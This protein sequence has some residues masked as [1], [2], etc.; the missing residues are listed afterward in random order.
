MIGLR[1]RRR[2]GGLLWGVGVVVAVAWGLS[3]QASGAGVRGLG[4]SVAMDV[5]A[6]EEG[7]LASLDVDLHDPVAAGQVL[8][9][10]DGSVIE[11]ERRELAAEVLAVADENVS[12]TVADVKAYERGRTLG[13]RAEIAGLELQLR[14]L[15]RLREEGAATAA[16]V[17]EVRAKLA[18]TRAKLAPDAP[19]DDDP[20]SSWWVDVALGRLGQADARLESY[21]LRS[22]LTGRVEAI[23]RRPGEMVRGGDPIVRVREPVAREV[24]AWATSDLVPAVGSVAVVLRGDGSRLAGT[25][26]SVGDGPTMLPVQ[27]LLDPSRQEWGVA[28]RVKL[29]QGTV[30]P[31]EPVLVRLT[32]TG[33]T[34]VVP[35]P[36][37]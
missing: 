14:R 3:E 31:D 10:L 20:T 7:R 16:E 4:R 32:P 37:W 17:E 24:I 1:G 34:S 15:S 9:R 21:T 29:D 30:G 33:P 28:V 36:T 35:S 19:P 8:A 18:S 11:Q 23:Y 27:A 22:G 2:I 12:A 25:V 5:G 6:P 26:H 13:T